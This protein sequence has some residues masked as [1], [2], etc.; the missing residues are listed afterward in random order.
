MSD[1]KTLQAKPNDDYKVPPTP[2]FSSLDNNPHEDER[3]GKAIK[4]DEDGQVIDEE[5]EIKEFEM[6]EP[7]LRMPQAVDGDSS[8][9]S[10]ITDDEDSDY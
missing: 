9:S 7:D 5:K 10:F 6:E 3:S 4:K 2:R 8:D 1:E